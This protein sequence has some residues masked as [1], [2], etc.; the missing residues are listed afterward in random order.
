MKPGG[1][2]DL[3]PE[4]LFISHRAIATAKLANNLDAINQ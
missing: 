1:S 3:M 2:S 4:T